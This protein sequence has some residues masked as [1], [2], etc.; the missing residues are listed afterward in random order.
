MS[1]DDAMAWLRRRWW[2]VVALV[3][4]LAAMALLAR[5]AIDDSHERQRRSAEAAAQRARIERLA[6]S[7]AAQQAAIQQSLTILQSVTSPEAQARN[8]A[9]L[10]AAIA[11][12]RRSIDCTK[13][14]DEG[15]YPACVE[16]AAR[17]DAIR[18][19]LDPFTRP[20]PTTG[21]PT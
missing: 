6:E 17:L 9:N 7:V 21:A 14:D 13:L 18:A 11:E 16:V 20:A 15:T 8:A 12:I 5:S 10:A 4:F 19:G 2:V 3:L 1:R